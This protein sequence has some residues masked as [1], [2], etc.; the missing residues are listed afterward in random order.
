M[1]DPSVVKDLKEI[2]GKRIYFGHQSVGVDI[3]NGVKDLVARAGGVGPAMITVK[4]ST[5]VPDAFIADSFVGRNEDPKS[6]C[7]DFGRTIASTFKGSL[8]IALMKYCYAD[9]NVNLD[10]D[11]AFAAYVT[12]L[13]RLRLEFPGITFVRKSVV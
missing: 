10:P 3:M 8:D 9:I 11:T 6:K 4:D 1:N 7:D 5:E 12:T 2:Q 13:D